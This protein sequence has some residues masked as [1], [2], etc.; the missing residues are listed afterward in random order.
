M[1]LRYEFEMTTFDDYYFA[2]PIGIN[3][4]DFHG[5]IK[6]N[7]V[8]KFIFELLKEDITEEEIVN[9]LSEEYDAPSSLIMEDVSRCINEFRER[10]LLF[11]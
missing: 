1:K 3:V 5:V 4:N 6:L 10:D 11:E 2:V 9:R 7:E 8:S